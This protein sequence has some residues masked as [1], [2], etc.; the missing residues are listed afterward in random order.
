M[1][2][3]DGEPG[4]WKQF[5]FN[6]MMTARELSWPRTERA[7]KLL[8][9]MRGEAAFFL[10]GQP[11][12]VLEDYRALKG[13]LNERY[14]VE[15]TPTVTAVIKGEVVDAAGARVHEQVEGKIEE[16][17][18]IAITN[19]EVLGSD[20]SPPLVADVTYD[21]IPEIPLISSISDPT[22]I[23]MPM[24]EVL[25]SEMST[26]P[27]VPLHS[28]EDH[29]VEL[30]DEVVSI[31]PQVVVQEERCED[32]KE[33]SVIQSGCHQVCSPLL[34]DD[35]GVCVDCPDVSC[36]AECCATADELKYLE[37][38]QTEL[39][40]RRIIPETPA[41]AKGEVHRP[42][43][44]IS[45]MEDVSVVLT[46]AYYS[47]RHLSFPWD[48]GGCTGRYHSGTDDHV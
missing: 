34:S 6:F 2:Y 11:R 33:S 35:A 15:K 23:P 46:A 16:P 17:P 10:A 24:G 25:G 20:D 19:G 26:I 8:T 37:V 44:S 39:I 12:E 18:A 36:A 21:H 42:G 14:R 32:E 30:L 4:D 27:A 48:P 45:L 43:I 47:A 38:P 3:F 31:E 9:C 13:V 29:M 28:H 40:T 7:E 22:A 41:I 1:L 5:L